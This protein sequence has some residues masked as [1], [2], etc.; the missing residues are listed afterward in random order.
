MTRNRITNYDQTQN[1]KKLSQSYHKVSYKPCK[2]DPTD[3]TRVGD[4]NH[5]T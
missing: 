5:P 3:P 4:C 1:L 2:D